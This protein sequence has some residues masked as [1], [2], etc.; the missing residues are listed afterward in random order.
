M[1]LA[2]G[3]D[4]ERTERLKGLFARGLVPRELF[5]PTEW[6]LMERESG[7]AAIM[8]TAKEALLKALGCGWT[9]GPVYGPDLELH[10]GPDDAIE[11][12]CRGEAKR[13]CRHASVAAAAFGDHVVATAL[14]GDV[15]RNEVA[16]RTVVVEIDSVSAMLEAVAARGERTAINGT[17]FSRTASFFAGRM[18]AR[19]SIIR[20]I[21]SLD[22]SC[23]AASSDVMI[24]ND[25]AGRPVI[26][27]PSEL[28]SPVVPAFSISHSR[29][30]A[31]AVAAARA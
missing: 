14:V 1:S 5:R 2:C 30:Y 21:R 18:A 8:F 13:R 3:V 25:E 4:I 7:L 10:V 16:I 24:G 28:M 15:P 17:G 26:S 11:V 20:L 29:K 6:E 12:V 19:K 9:L 27:N 23:R 22:P 31:V